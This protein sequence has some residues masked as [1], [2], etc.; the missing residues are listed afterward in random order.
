M[1]GNGDSLFMFCSWKLNHSDK[2][3]YAGYDKN[4]IGH[5]FCKIW[6]KY[7][8]LVQYANLTLFDQYVPYWAQQCP[9][10]LKYWAVEEAS[11]QSLRSTNRYGY[12]AFRTDNVIT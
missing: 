5:C 6:Q 1:Y 4:F 3:K 7:G 11:C 2:S 8:C 10:N 12:R 9:I